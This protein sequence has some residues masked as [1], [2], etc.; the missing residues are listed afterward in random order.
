[1]GWA[2]L[3][4]K[5]HDYRF[6]FWQGDAELGRHM[7]RERATRRLLNQSRL[8]FY[9]VDNAFREALRPAEGFLHSG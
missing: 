1:M 7:L 4:S 8:R 3:A 6:A 9:L 5:Q 2:P